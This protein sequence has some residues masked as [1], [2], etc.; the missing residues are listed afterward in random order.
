ML[1]FRSKIFFVCCVLLLLTGCSKYPKRGQSINKGE[2]VKSYSV[3]DISY[4]RYIPNG[5]Y[6][7]K[8]QKMLDSLLNRLPGQNNTTPIDFTSHSVIGKYISGGCSL[9]IIRELCIDHTRREYS[10][11]I[12]FKDS[13]ICFAKAEDYNLVVVPKI[14]DNYTVSF[15]VKE[16]R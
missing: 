10:Y 9:R 7:I 14:P 11:T 2:I 15:R 5:E 8:D 16:G 6:I 4:I 13:G 12:R 3:N 1:L